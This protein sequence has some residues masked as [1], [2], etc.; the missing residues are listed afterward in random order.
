L[1]FILLAATRLIAQDTI[2]LDYCYRMVEKNWPLGRQ[3]ELYAKSNALQVQ[4]FNKNWLPYLNI[5]GS[6]SYQNDVPMVEI[7]LPAGLP[8]LSMPLP[9]KDQYKLWLDVTQPVYDANVTSYQ[10]KVEGFNL[11]VNQEN[12]KVELYKLKDQ[13]NQL[14]FS[15]LLFVESEDLLK[16][17]R[18]LVDSRLKEIRSGVAN[19]TM[20]QSSADALEAEIIQLDQQIASLKQDMSV[21][22]K[23]LS[24]LI[25]VPIPETTRLVLPQITISSFDY[26]NKRLEYE[27]F[28]IQQGRV[29]VL[30][31]MVTTR[32]NPRFSAFGQLGYGRPGFNVLSNDFTT[33]WIVGGRLTWN[34]YN[35]GQN[36]NDKKIYDIQNDILRTQKE[37]FDKNLRITADRNLSEI[38]KVTELLQQDEALINLRAKIVKTASSQLDNGVITSSDYIDRVNEET[39]ARLNMELH[40]IQLVKAKMTYLYTLGKL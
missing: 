12:V 10:K 27:L 35:W 36:K 39:Q 31:N 5:G 7:P 16:S 26:D 8:Q 24:E 3:T 14:Y 23:M 21:A 32:W 17:S 18:N 4:N 6:V 2:T 40:K 9:A 28:D 1:L 13:V 22:Y 15:V 25:S 38:M 19:G 20:L 33:F 29:S 11:K 30:K 34:I 37:T